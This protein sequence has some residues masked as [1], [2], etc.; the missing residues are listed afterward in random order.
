MKLFKIIAMVALTM[1]GSMATAQA[2]LDTTGLTQAQI[3]ELVIQSEQMKESPT[4]TVET[5][6]EYAEFG[7]AFGSAI[8]ETAEQ[9]GATANDFIQT[10]AGKLS[11][12]LI[13]WKVAGDDLLGVVG[14]S[15]WFIIML[16][17]WIV[18]FHR[19][20]I[21]PRTVTALYKDAEG[22]QVP[23]Q[24]SIS[25]SEQERLDMMAFMMLAILCA[26]CGAGLIMIF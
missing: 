9:V 7:K 23:Y 22:N 19:M 21:A 26:I 18:F 14:G 2:A 1:F 17:L 16:P 5:L 6:G 24:T 4:S 25:G 12:A 13:V 11:V 8:A 10:P 20:V 3:A 15:I